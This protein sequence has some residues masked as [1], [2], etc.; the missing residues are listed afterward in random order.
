MTRA[1]LFA[2]YITAAVALVVYVYASIIKPAAL[3]VKD[4]L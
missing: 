2:C 4:A 3:I 1:I